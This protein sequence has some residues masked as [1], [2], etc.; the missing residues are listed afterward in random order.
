MTDKFHVPDERTLSHEEIR[1]LEWLLAHGRSDASQYMTQIP[2]LRVVSRCGCGCP[3]IDFAMSTG[4][5]DGPSHIIADAEGESP[6]G[7]RIGVIVHVRHGEISELEVFSAT[8]EENRSLPKPES[9]VP[10]PH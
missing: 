1:L 2:K 8:G 10:W 7:V 3:T 9:L 5:K 6:E 4:R